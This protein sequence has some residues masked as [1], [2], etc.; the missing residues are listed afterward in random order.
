MAFKKSALASGSAIILPMMLLYGASTIALKPTEGEEVCNPSKYAC[1][2]TPNLF[3]KQEMSAN[4]LRF[5]FREN[6]GELPHSNKWD[7]SSVAQRISISLLSPGGRDVEI[8][9]VWR[10][11]VYIQPYLDW[12][13]Y[14]GSFVVKGDGN[15]NCFFLG[16]FAGLPQNVPCKEFILLIPPG[17]EVKDVAFSNLSGEYVSKN[18]PMPG[19]EKEINRALQDS[20]QNP[21]DEIKTSLCLSL[22]EKAIP[23]YECISKGGG[24]PVPAWWLAD[25]R[26]SEE[27]I[28]YLYDTVVA[29]NNK[30]ALK[31]YMGFFSTSDGYIA[32]VMASR[33]CDILLD[34]PIL[35]LQ[36]WNDIGEFKELINGALIFGSSGANVKML[37]AYR[38][39]AMK[40][41]QYKS[42]CEEIIKIISEKY[43]DK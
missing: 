26:A 12:G 11:A 1:P 6:A 32:E 7:T 37:E 43:P 19:L 28:G 3:P 42:A 15:P 21:K 13:V 22:L 33:F 35:V 2:V 39:I 40:E 8:K 24:V 14:R 5:E 38:E 36:S 4:T 41:P 23:K 29:E 17:V 34:R 16:V 9:F 31:V 25:W 27:W 18:C 20:L 30:Y 10:G